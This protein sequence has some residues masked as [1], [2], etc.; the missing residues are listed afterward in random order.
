M[1][2]VGSSQASW[3]PAGQSSAAPAGAH[4]ATDGRSHLSPGD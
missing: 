3:Q 1:G 2:Q 4:E